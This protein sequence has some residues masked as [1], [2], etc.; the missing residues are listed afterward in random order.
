VFL[1]SRNSIGF[2]EIFPGKLAQCETG[3]KEGSFKKQ[4]GDGGVTPEMRQKRPK[5]IRTLFLLG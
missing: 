1:D 2:P 5:N 4:N 3:Y